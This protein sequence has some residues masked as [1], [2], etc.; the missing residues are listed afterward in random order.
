[1]ANIARLNVDLVARTAAFT[2]GL[3]SARSALNSFISPLGAVTAAAGALGM[4]LSAGAA[5][6]FVKSRM[7]EIDVLAKT[8][9][10]LGATTE[11]LIAYRHGAN[12]AGV[13]AEAFDKSLGKMVINIGEAMNGSKTAADA[14]NALG[15]N[16]NALRGLSADQ[17]FYAITAAMETIENQTQ[18]V[19]IAYDI[20]GRQGVAMLNVMKDGVEGLNTAWDDA[21]K[22]GLIFSREEAAQVEA[23]NDAMTRV[24]E[25]VKGVGNQLAIALAPRIEAASN[26]LTDFI[27]QWDEIG[28]KIENVA[29]TSVKG[30]ALM[31][32]GAQKGM[33]LIQSASKGL[34]DAMVES[35]IT[36]LED[37]R[38]RL[39]K[40]QKEGGSLI[41][42][43]LAGYSEDGNKI[44]VGF[45]D[46]SLDDIDTRIASLKESL[47]DIRDGSLDVS[48]MDSIGDLLG[49]DVTQKI[50]DF[51]AQFKSG[52]DAASKGRG[53][54]LDPE[55]YAADELTEK[56]KSLG[57]GKTTGSLR[58]LALNSRAS[59]ALDPGLQKVS[60]PQLGRTN[61]LLAQ[62]AG[63]TSRAP[64]A[65]AG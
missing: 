29:K 5:V 55:L 12:L 46:L 61:T 27:S 11:G 10:A 1:M 57:E 38:K 4:T 26:M 45:D 23:A 64:I 43:A 14:F 41:G 39:E 53:S 32:A 15:L 16:V 30:F 8:A 18:R 7:E 56:L 44:S 42:D 50:D 54:M 58:L 60:D 17:Q 21:D 3:S 24:G 6:A 33:A 49:T 59:N 48:F 51:F 31:A 63:N 62:I 2:R 47:S 13:G 22:L 35:Q 19:G 25:A 52:A 28:P 37:A 36:E 65:V 34:S 9:D 20:F 40:R